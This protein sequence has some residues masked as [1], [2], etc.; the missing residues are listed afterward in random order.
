METFTRII[1]FG[2]VNAESNR[3]IVVGG[4]NAITVEKMRELVGRP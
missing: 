4:V 3:Y 2:E 1:V